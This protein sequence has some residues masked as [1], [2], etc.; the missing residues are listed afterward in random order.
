MQKTFIFYTDPSHGWV[1][2]PVKIL[3]RF[4]IARSISRF[5]Y[6]RKGYA[7]L[8]EDSDFII[9]LKAMKAEGFKYHF[10]NR[11]TDRSSRIRNYQSYSAGEV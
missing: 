3:N 4:K 6:Y 5:S 2:V 1:K 10:D 7:Y 8:E 11:F 9:F